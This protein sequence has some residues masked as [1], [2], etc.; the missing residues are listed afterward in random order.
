MWR[1]DLQAPTVTLAVKPP[2]RADT[3]SSSAL[4]VIVSSAPHEIQLW[5]RYHAPDSVSG[6]WTSATFGSGMIRLD[7]LIPG[8]T[9]TIEVYGQDAVGNVGL[10]VS[11]TWVSPPCAGPREAPVHNLVSHPLDYGERLVLWDDVNGTS[12]TKFDGYEYSLDGGVVW[13]ATRA[14]YVILSNLTEVGACTGA[15]NNV[16]N[17]LFST[18]L[19]ADA[20]A[21]L[22][23]D[24]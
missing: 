16:W 6:P 3:P 24:V 19:S 22:S 14:A 8:V 17:A 4:F 23:L 9:Y 7:D 12:T 1:V 2:A 10:P 13:L 21:L 15:A 18:C 20:A 11:W 5:Y